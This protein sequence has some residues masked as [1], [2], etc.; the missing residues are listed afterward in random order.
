MSCPDPD[1]RWFAPLR[2]DGSSSRRPV[3]RA[4]VAL[5]VLGVLS[6]AAIANAES[7]DDRFARLSGEFLDHWL[8]S[9]PQAATRLGLHTH[10]DRL[11]P[12]TQASLI[13]EAAW[14]REFRTRLNGVP[15]AGLTFEHQLDRDVL[16]SR[17]ESQ[18]LDLEVIRPFEN[19]PNSYLDLVAGSIQSLLQRNFAPL[20][21]RLKLTT[22][23]LEQ[24]PEVLRAASLNIKN[25]PRIATE[26]AISQFEGVLRLYREQ[27]PAIA[28]HCKDPRA[29]ADLA[30]ADSLAVKAIEKFLTYLRNDV[31]PRSNGSYALG[32]ETY[33]KK[34]LYDEMEET[35]VDTLLAR[36]NAALAETRA[37]MEAVAEK[38]VPGQGVRAALTEIERDHPSEQTLVPYVAAELDSIRAFLRAHDLITLPLR[39]NLIVRETPVFRRST[40]FAS[41]E[42]PGVWERRASEA[43]FNVTPVDSSWNEQQKRDHLAFFNRYASQIVSIHEALPG[44]YYQ[45]LALKNVPSRL[46]QV[47]GS[48]SNT[49]GWAH[50]CEQMAIEQGYGNGDPRYELAQLDLALQRIGRFVVG[51]SLHTQGMTYEEAEKLFEDQCYMAPINAAREARRGT[52][53][54]TYLVYTLG[55]WRILELREEVRAK[56]GPAF[57][58]R[59]FHDALLRQG[60]SPLP[61]VRAGVLRELKIGG[62]GGGS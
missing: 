50:Y 32:K 45:F 28:S 52:M 55:K 10:D 3:A 49:E 33:Q 27:I 59:T 36:G 18:L 9:R 46:R 40:S 1:R 29:Q 19:N 11:V 15:R 2:A 42:S 12:V 34:L 54:P 21:A 13:E 35:P 16:A 4:A 43:Y 5:V 57:K 61:V 20:C 31:M 6:L 48:G 39:E 37:R 44:H 7:Q 25:P 41:M 56:L 38:I 30:E 24:V 53:D 8:A 47:F 22:R 60:S 62:G 26:T 58:L 17:I 23:R 14:L 51:I